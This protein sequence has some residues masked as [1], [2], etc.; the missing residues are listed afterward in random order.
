MV[1]LGA[2]KPAAALRLLEIDNIQ[3]AIGMHI[4]GLVRPLGPREIR[5]LR[6][7]M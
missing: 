7:E 2:A 1:P 5:F 3:A 4:C 6:S